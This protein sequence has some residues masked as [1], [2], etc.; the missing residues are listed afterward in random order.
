MTNTDKALLLAEWGWPPSTCPVCHSSGTGATHQ[1]NC[2]MDLAL[3]E[4]GYCSRDDRAR[5]RTFITS[6]AQTLPP[7]AAHGDSASSD[8]ELKDHDDGSHP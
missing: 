2:A 5:G 8:G 3:S 1:P 4:R 6:I 7:P